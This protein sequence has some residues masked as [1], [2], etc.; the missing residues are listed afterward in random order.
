MLL[1]TA[2][3]T[4]KL[5]GSSSNENLRSLFHLPQF[6]DA[7]KAAKN[8]VYKETDH[9]ELTNTVAI[10]GINDLKL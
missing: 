4:R 10:I 1:R 6:Y 2:Q 7:A 3:V 9:Q 5:F 8:G